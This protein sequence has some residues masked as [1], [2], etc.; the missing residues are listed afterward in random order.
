MLAWPLSQSAAAEQLTI[1]ER[2]ARLERNS[3]N[4]QGI[5]ELVTQIQQLQQ[6]LAEL[7]GQ[8]EQ[9]AATGF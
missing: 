2:L 4:N 1:Q 9:Q 7:R 3:G 5:A 8:L 6:E